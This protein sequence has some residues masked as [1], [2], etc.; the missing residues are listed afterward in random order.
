MKI[1]SFLPVSCNI[2]LLLLFISYF[3]IHMKIPLQ[4]NKK[5]VIPVSQFSQFPINKIK[6]HSFCLFNYCFTWKYF[7]L[8]K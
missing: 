7:I 4:I 6:F 3:E 2:L 5:N 1:K 8:Q